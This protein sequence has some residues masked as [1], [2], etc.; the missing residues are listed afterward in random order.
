[1]SEKP[2]EQVLK[3][4][5][6][7]WMA[8]PGVIGTAIGLA[9]GQPCIKISLACRAADLSAPLPSEI[10]GYPIVLQETGPIRLL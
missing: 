5:T 8:I 4:H 3:E 7:Q 1:M 10:D 9:R 2:I 6:P